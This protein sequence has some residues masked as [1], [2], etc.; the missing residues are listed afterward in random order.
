MVVVGLIGPPCS[1]KRTTARLLCD[2]F[3]YSIHEL[4]HRPCSPCVVSP[5]ES[6]SGHSVGAECES[7]SLQIPQPSFEEIV[8][9]MET[10][11]KLVSR[12][13]SQDWRRNHV[14]FPISHKCQ[15]EILSRRPYFVLVAVEAPLQLRFRRH[16]ERNKSVIVNSLENFADWDDQVQY[17]SRPILSFT[18]KSA[19][20]VR[21]GSDEHN[22]DWIPSP[23][24]YMIPITCYVQLKSESFVTK[25]TSRAVAIT[26]AELLF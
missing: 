11:M 23:D 10:E 25:Q 22:E 26:A 2:H 21:R 5:P 24:S 12:K 3:G 14:V 16:T 15:L 4:R 19:E 8:G 13:V 7:N 6:S 20:S 17:G 18:E 1:G 9:L